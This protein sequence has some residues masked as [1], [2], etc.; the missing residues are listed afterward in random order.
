MVM[1]ITV[2]GHTDSTG[3]EKRNSILSTQRAN[4]VKFYFLNK[5][6][7]WIEIISAMGKAS[8]FPI[9]NNKTEKGRAA[10]RRVKIILAYKNKN[11]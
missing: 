3:T 8:S 11:N 7:Q 5:R 9:A 6:P 2:E 10:N 1:G 4:A